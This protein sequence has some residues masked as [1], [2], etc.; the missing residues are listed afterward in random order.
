M[1]PLNLLAT[2]APHRRLFATAFAAP[3]EGAGLQSSEPVDFHRIGCAQQGR[4]GRP[5]VC[6]K[7]NCPRDRKS[8]HWDFGCPDHS[9]KCC[10]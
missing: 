10:I 8:V 5:A 6:Y 9:W 1:Q 4:P 3:D 2:F 7:P